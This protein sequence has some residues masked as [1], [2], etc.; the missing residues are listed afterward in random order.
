MSFDDLERV[1]RVHIPP[2]YKQAKPAPL[3]LAF[4]GWGGDENDYLDVPLVRDESDRRGFIIVAPRGI[5]SGEP[6]EKNNSWSFR[7]STSGVD[8]EGNP[9][10]DPELTP[11]YAYPSCKEA[12]IAR[13]HCA[14]THC[15]GS[16]GGDANFTMALLQR[17]EADLC[18]DT[19]RIYAT[20]S[21]NGGMFTW[22]LAQNPV[23]APAFRA[24][25][26]NIGLPHRGY[27]DGPAKGRGIPVLLT[28]GTLDMTVPPGEWENDDFT[29]TRDVDRFYYTS[30][31]AMM[32][33]WSEAHGCSSDQAAV[34]VEAGLNG[35]DCRSYCREDPG[36]TRVLDCRARM[37][38]EAGLPWSWK[39]TLD[40]FDQ[41]GG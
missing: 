27:A 28:T 25:A 41:H 5:G 37:G 36:L 20:G 30:A 8:V 10:C 29:T 24:I 22:E 2:Q 26:P 12:G 17:L 19:G 16:P 32:R 15:Q 35:I 34:R 38:H 1:Y 40:F 11:E 13:N 33:V 4:H 3:V 7:G 39:L 31:T 14:W 21:S 23:S 18:I 6:D 9:I